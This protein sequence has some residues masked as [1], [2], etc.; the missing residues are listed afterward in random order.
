MLDVVII[1][2]GTAGLS[3]AIYAK[4]A[5]LDAVV[6]EKEYLGISYFPSLEEEKN[7]KKNNY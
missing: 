1:G 5:N 2:S 3:A 7:D 4:R 6:L